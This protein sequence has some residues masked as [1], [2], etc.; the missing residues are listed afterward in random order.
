MCAL[1][2]GGSSVS[3]GEDSPATPSSRRKPMRVS[4]IARQAIGL[5]DLAA[6]LGSQGVSVTYHAK[7]D[8]L[9]P[10]TYADKAAAAPDIV[11]LAV[12]GDL[13]SELAIVRRLRADS[14]VL[15]MAIASEDNEESRITLLEAGC[16]DCVM[17]HTTPREI[18]ARMRAMLRR[19]ATDHGLL[20]SAVPEAQAIRQAAD[21]RKG[22]LDLG[23]GWKLCCTR[24]EIYRPDGTSCAATTA[25]FNL[26]ACLAMQPG[27]PV[28]R[29]DISQAVYRRNYRADD[30]SVDNLVVRLRRKLETDPQEP[31]VLRSVRLIGYMFAGF[32]PPTVRVKL[33]RFPRQAKTEFAQ[34][35]TT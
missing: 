33:P 3:G 11:V 26:L 27:V 28:S 5:V 9:F 31:K 8:E 12:Q 4:V 13:R 25:E 22:P 30:R 2:L 14:R 34:F 32:E 6:Y 29:D 16:D 10:E 18:L 19:A 15:C 21:S 20:P 23:L 1:D 24:R 17:N 7:A 35:V